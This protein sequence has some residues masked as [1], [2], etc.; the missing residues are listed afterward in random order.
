[1]VSRD[2]IPN[3]LK[4]Y[5]KL[6]KLISDSRYNGLIDWNA[7]E[8]RGRV[9]NIPSSW[10]SISDIIESAIRSYRLPRWS[11]Q[12]NY[13]ELLTEKDALSSILEP[14]ASKWHIPFVVNKGYASSTAIYNM[15]KR[16][17]EK[18]SNGKQIHIFYLGDHDPS[19]LDMNR[20]I[21]DRLKEFIA[22]DWIY[23]V[24]FRHIALTHEQ[25]D[26]YKPPPNPA[27][28]QDPRAGKYISEFGTSS[29]EVDALR[30]EV[31]VDVIE[32]AIK[33]IIDEE[34]YDVWLEKE[35]EHKGE[36]RIAAKE[37]K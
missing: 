30:P 32:D 1:M 35:Q 36:L 10:D 20:D 19:G 12:D 21:I 31:M 25:I 17:I 11:D 8:D 29:W 2:I 15:S 33:G 28:V 37:I 18:L 16:L 6:S 27:K 5:S 23:E 13:I 3:H 4:V 14:I 26:R 7:I 9:P 34:K 22:G 24:V